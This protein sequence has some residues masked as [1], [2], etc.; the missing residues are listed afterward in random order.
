[1]G[2]NFFYIFFCY[3]NNYPFLCTINIMC[4]GKQQKGK[5]KDKRA[6]QSQV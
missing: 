2:D 3:V 4:H 5:S 6:Y 1:M